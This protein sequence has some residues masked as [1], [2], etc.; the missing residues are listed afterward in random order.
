M[1][2]NL[3]V[4]VDIVRQDEYLLDIGASD[5]IVDDLRIVVADRDKFPDDC[6]D[7]K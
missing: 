4:E 2:C 6:A 7:D 3:S 1:V 5:L